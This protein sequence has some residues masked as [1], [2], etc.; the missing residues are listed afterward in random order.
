MKVI[1]QI[2]S[3]QPFG[4]PFEPVSHAAQAI[5]VATN[6]LLDEAL[7]L[8]SVSDALQLAATMR[9]LRARVDA[10]SNTALDKADELSGGH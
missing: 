1:G 3:S 8:T 6:D 2:S 9:V 7:R 4:A 10:V 5:Y